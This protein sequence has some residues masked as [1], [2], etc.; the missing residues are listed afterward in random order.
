VEDFKK[1]F[2]LVND[3]HYRV[4]YFVQRSAAKDGVGE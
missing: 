2:R 4:G 3:S 1:V